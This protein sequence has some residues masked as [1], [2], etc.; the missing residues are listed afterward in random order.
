[1]C[2]Y[3]FN[4]KFWELIKHFLYMWFFK[5]LNNNKFWLGRCILLYSNYRVKWKRQYLFLHRILWILM[6]RI[7]KATLELFCV[8]S[9]ELNCFSI[10]VV[11]WLPKIQRINNMEPQE[12][13]IAR[14]NIYNTN[15][16]T[17]M[18]SRASLAP[19][20]KLKVKK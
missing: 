11:V 13:G 12:M 15:F 2:I 7:L 3:F 18:W 17:P 16:Q 8:E 6:V 5:Y 4:W 20:I 10:T 14:F 1:M 19:Y 9:F